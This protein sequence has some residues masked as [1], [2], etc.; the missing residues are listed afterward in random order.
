M[1]RKHKLA[2]VKLNQIVC[3][4]T[5]DKNGKETREETEG[6]SNRMR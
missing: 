1:F 3:S 4:V 5:N 2:H 6:K